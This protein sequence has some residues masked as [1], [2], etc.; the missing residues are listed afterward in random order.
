[1]A[2]LRTF[3][4]GLKRPYQLVWLVIIGLTLL[5]LGCIAANVAPWLRGPE[6]WRWAYAIPGNW[7]RHLIP[8]AAI[9]S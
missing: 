7:T 2:T 5:L 4:S 8:L 1:M 9:A 6:E 3:F